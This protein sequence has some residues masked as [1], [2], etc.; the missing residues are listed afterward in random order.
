MPS[1]GRAVVIALLSAVGALPV[2]ACHAAPQEIP[3]AMTGASDGLDA[4]QISDYPS[5]IDA[6]VRVLVQKFELPVPPLTLE[7]HSTREEFE[8]GLIKDLGLKPALARSTA[9]FAKAAV[10]VRVVLINE[11]AV[12]ELSWP[13]RIELLA[14][15]LAHTVQLGLTGQRPLNRQQWLTEGFA[16]WIAYAVTD[17]LGLDD[18][19]RARSRIIGKLQ[20]TQRVGSLPRLAQ[21]D[22]FAQWIAARTKY[23]YDAT[24]SLSFLVVEFLIGRHSFNAILDYFRRFRGSANYVGNFNSA[25][26]ESLD[27]FE[28][29]L[30]RHLA[31]L[32]M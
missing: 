5:A 27:D 30:D 24:F 31:Q 19:S 25:F 2:L 16:E 18:M 3:I 13:D 23:G 6:I 1:V 29:E 7:I 20:A 12:A 9:A 14:H 11:L 15:E 28:V 4:R 8:A 32:L 26:G 17:S 21:L 22:A 10:G